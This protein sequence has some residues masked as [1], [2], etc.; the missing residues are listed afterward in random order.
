M[1]LSIPRRLRS[2]VASA[3]L[4]AAVAASACSSAPQERGATGLQGDVAA[5]P[6]DP[7]SCIGA[8]MTRDQAIAL[9]APGATDIVVGSYVIQKRSRPCNAV[10]GCGAWGATTT[11]LGSSIGSLSPDLEMKGSL[12]LKVVGDDIQLQLIDVTHGDAG[13]ACSSVGGPQTCSAYEYVMGYQWGGSG[14]EFPTWSTVVKAD[15]KGV[16]L[17]GV[18]TASCVRLTDRARSP[19]AEEEYV[20]YATLAPPSTPSVAACPEDERIMRCGARAPGQTTCCRRGLTTC[21][22]TGCDCWAKCD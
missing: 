2:L 14:G 20:L 4:I 22:Q 1:I 11:R 18:L 19:Q 15:S 12:H 21:P 17:G 16:A 3:P 6:F 9:F 7:A 8:P 13:S 10:T 5:D